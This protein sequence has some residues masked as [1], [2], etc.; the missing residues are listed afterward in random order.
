MSLKSSLCIALLVL[1][2][3]SANDCPSGSASCVA[4]TDEM[5]ALQHVSAHHSTPKKS[6]KKGGGG[7]GPHVPGK[8]TAEAVVSYFKNSVQGKATKQSVIESIIYSNANFYPTTQQPRETMKEIIEYMNSLAYQYE[9]ASTWSIKDK[10]EEGALSAI[11]VESNMTICNV[12]YPNALELFFLTKVDSTWRINAYQQTISN[13]LANP[14]VPC[15]DGK[16]PEVTNVGGVSLPDQE[17]T[18]EQTASIF[19][20]AE[21]YGGSIM[22]PSVPGVVSAF[23]PDAEASLHVYPPLTTP[24]DFNNI[25]TGFLGGCSPILVSSVWPTYQQAE[26]GLFALAQYTWYEKFSNPTD[27]A[28]PGHGLWVLTRESEEDDFKARFFMFNYVNAY[29]P[30]QCFG[31]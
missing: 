12:A 8:D 28:A 25:Y 2:S 31:R 17:M 19:A 23:T 21:L 24:A 10:F 11:V 18:A 4:E 26:C 20:T 5:A 27:Y 13:I 30:P 7:H 29:P 16:T 3:V 14:L 9:F 6:N 1:E 22:E 15:K